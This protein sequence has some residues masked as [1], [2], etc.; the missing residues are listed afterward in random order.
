MEVNTL[1]QADAYEWLC[2]LPDNAVHCII[3]SPPYWGLRDYGVGGQI[4]LE[5]TLSQ[6]L[7]R[8]TVVFR[9]ARRVLRDD[10]VMWLN[11]GQSWHNKQ[12]TGQPHKLAFSLQDDGWFL[13]STIVWH[14]PNPMPS[15][16]T[17]R[18]NQAHEYVFL[19]TKSARY[20]YDAFAVREGVTGG[21]H[22]HGG[23]M[24]AKMENAI[25]LVKS[26][27]PYRN[28]TKADLPTSRNKRTVWTVATHPFS[29]AHF[30]TFPPKLI[31]PMILAGCPPKVCVECG[32]PWERVVTTDYESYDGATRKPC[33]ENH[34]GRKH[35][36]YVNSRGTGLRKLETHTGWRP[37]CEHTDAD[38]E[39]GIVM[40]FFMGSGTVGLVAIQHGRRW[41]GCELSAEYVAMANKRLSRPIQVNMFTS[42]GE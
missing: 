15:S 41:I 1:T 23:G 31:E 40:D 24:G 19:M 8:L 36:G 39:P 38:T 10:G 27:V 12:M 29:E 42:E 13:R 30:A 6:Y 35:T 16:Q 11:M 4:G 21:A 26:S 25:G 37:I 28:E 18:P 5:E 34:G 22:A 32:S 2:S 3:T 20:W 7:E 14:K 9:E 17:D 33:G